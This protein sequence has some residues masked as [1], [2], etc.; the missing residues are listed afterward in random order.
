MPLESI[1]RYARERAVSAK[2]AS[3]VFMQVI[4]L[5]H[6]SAPKA[7]FMGGTALVLGH[8]N[9]RFSEDVDLS[10]IA[11]P[12]ILRPGLARAAAELRGWF[13]KPVILHAPKETSRTW[14]LACRLSRS[15]TLQ[16]HVDSQ[17]YRAYTSEPIVVSFPS[18]APFVCEAM[19][20]DEIMA[21]KIVALAFRRYLGGR[22]LFDLWFHWLRSDDWAARRGSI[23][24]LLPKKLKERSLE[25]SDFRRRLVERLSGK[26]PLDRAEDEWRRYLPPNFQKK[27]VAEEILAKT[28]RLLE[29]ERP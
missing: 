2:E 18:I 9:P 16:L 15:E 22:D 3:Q 6:L 14:R 19:G 26:T 27:T 24:A 8:G 12:D 20:V 4:V 10:Q 11:D 21:E 23:S 17:P 29:M 13:G 28:R 1:Q 5:R 25:L 7:C